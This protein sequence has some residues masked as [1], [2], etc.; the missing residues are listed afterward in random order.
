MSEYLLFNLVVLISPFFAKL[1]YP[2]AVLPKGTKTIIAISIPAL[3]FILWDICVTN[4][5]WSFNTK[6]ILGIYLI[7]VPIEEWLFFFSVPYACLF[8]WENLNTPL[9]KIK[10]TGKSYVSFIVMLLFSG[11]FFLYQAIYY[12]GIDLLVF[13]AVVA[14][15]FISGARLIFSKKT[16]VFSVILLLLIT[17]FNYYLTARPVVIYNLDVKTSFYVLTIPVEDFI[18][19]FSL[20]ILQ[21]IIY[22]RV[23][24]FYKILFSQTQQQSHK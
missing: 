5:F 16:A 18:Y 12:T 20:I 21:L 1:V 8:I 7:G 22:V 19:G 4:Y 6:Y 11:I 3:I 17:I 14:F 10:Q 23:P 13:A 24:Y 15:D 2:N 9:I